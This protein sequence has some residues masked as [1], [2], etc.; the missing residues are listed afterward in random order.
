MNRKKKPFLIL[1]LV[2]AV[3]L[4][5]PIFGWAM[6]LHVFGKC[7]QIIMEHE[8]HEALLAALKPEAVLLLVCSGLIV[9]GVLICI[10]LIFWISAN[11]L[12]LSQLLLN[13]ILNGFHAMQDSGGL[14]TVDTWFD[15]DS[16]FL[17]VSDT[18]CGIPENILPHIFDPFFTTKE[19]GKGIGLGLAIAAQVVEE[20]HGS[21]HVDSQVGK[22]SEFTVS[23]PRRTEAECGSIG[24]LNKY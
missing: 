11:E 15:E 2:L 20:H 24:N 22:G 6:V 10:I 21:I 14:M 3:L 23:L 7:E 8:S 16:V 5:I 1:C 9:M 17:S 19:E 12:Q 4:G 18:G 13:L